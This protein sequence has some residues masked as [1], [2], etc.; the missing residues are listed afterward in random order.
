[1]VCYTATGSLK[2]SVNQDSDIYSSVSKP[3]L[4]LLSLN[5]MVGI[6]KTRGVNTHIISERI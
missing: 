2:N 5:Y 4:K 3:I 1:V 6:N